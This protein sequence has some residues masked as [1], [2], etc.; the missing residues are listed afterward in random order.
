M[1]H[2]LTLVHVAA[3]SALQCGPIRHAEQAE[4]NEPEACQSGRLDQR[5]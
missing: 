2:V 5:Q 1:C 3:V 4:E